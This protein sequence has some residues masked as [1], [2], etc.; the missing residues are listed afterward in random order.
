MTRLVLLAALSASVFGAGLSWLVVRPR[1]RLSIR[2]R[3]YAALSRSRLGT[4]Y[5][6]VSVVALTQP[7]DSGIMMRVFGP[8][9]GRLALTLASLIDATDDATL[10]LR[11]RQAG[12]VDPRPEQYRIRQL[13]YAV[14]G[15][16]LGLGLG[17][18]T[19]GTP[20]G[21]LAMGAMFG[22]PAATLQRNRVNRAIEERRTRMRTEVY[23][24]AQLIAVHI[25]AGHGPVESVRLVAALG[26]GPV[27]EE[28]RELL[29]WVSSG[30]SPQRAYEKLGD[31]T[32]EP[33]AARL[34]RLLSASARSGGD[35]ASA[36]LA[37]SDDLRGER[38]EEVSRTAVKR[39]T[40]ML[41]PLLLFIAPVMVLFVG[42]ALPS[43][44]LGPGH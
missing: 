31:L 24:V 15:V 12:F 33:A 17:L 34:Y 6:D 38:R 40:A 22:F 16:V 35:I 42:A 44:V 4:G 19:L 13:A 18:V 29:G 3:P 43:L 25:R 9:L 8:I 7:S 28:L 23:T 30:T 10:G 21:T 1:R 32:P 39:R 27:V 11:L 41:V 36:L 5:A 37:V 26:R 20:I 2:I 14:G